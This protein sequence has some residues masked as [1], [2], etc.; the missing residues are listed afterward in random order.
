MPN[1]RLT[2]IV[3]ELP[4][5]KKL[6]GIAS[7]LMALSLFFPWYQDVDSFRTG[8]TFTGL[9]GPMYLAG[10]SF[11]VLASVSLLFMVMD[12]LNRQVPL[13]K[14][15]TSKFHLWSGIFSFYLLFMVG[16]AYFHPAFGVNITLKQSGFGMFL[17]YSAAALM[18]VGGYLEGRGRA[19]VKE[20][21]KETREPAPQKSV[22]EE[23]V[24]HKMEKKV[25]HPL[26]NHRKPRDLKQTEQPVKPVEQPSMNLEPSANEPEP[27]MPV[28]QQVQTMHAAPQRQVQPIS[29][30]TA[31]RKA[32]PF[33]MDL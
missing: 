9:T 18:T 4:F 23:P 27:L 11:L 20:F 29:E 28:Q 25:V 6:V 22:A 5:E 32:Q 19:A 31:E 26:I 10:F 1:P 14:I 17:A 30:P 24:E 13:F 3:A 33:R 8:D 7:I 2:Q 12:Y 21:E 15:K 16:S